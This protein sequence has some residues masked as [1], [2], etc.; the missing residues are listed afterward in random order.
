MGCFVE[1]IE[2]QYGESEVRPEMYQPYN[3]NDA[4]DN[5]NSIEALSLEN[6]VRMQLMCEKTFLESK[7]HDVEEFIA[8]KRT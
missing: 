2:T 6:N 7:E 4:T 5:E 8:L 3:F 1:L